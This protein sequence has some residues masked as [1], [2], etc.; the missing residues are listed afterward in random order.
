MKIWGVVLTIAAT[1]AGCT[2]QGVISASSD[3]SEPADSGGPPGEDSGVSPDGGGEP[4]AA[5]MIDSGVHPDAS[6]EDAG[7][8][9]GQTTEDAGKSDAGRLDAGTEKDAGDEIDAGLDAGTAGIDAGEVDAGSGRDAGN[10]TDAGAGKDGGPDAGSATDAGCVNTVVTNVLTYHN[11]LARTGQYLTEA[12]L[13]PSTVNVKQFG[14]LF[15][16]NVDGK[17]DAQPLYMQA[18]TVNGALHNVVFVA[19]EHDSLYAFD[20]DSNA[21]ANANPL[22]KVSLLGT[23]ETTSDTRSC[24]Q[25]TP[26]IGITAT[27]V[28]D[29]TNNTIYVVAMSKN[30]AGTYF[31]RLHAINVLTGAER[32]GSPVTVQAKYPGT[33]DNSSGGF[34]IFDPKQYK[35]RPGLLLLNGQVYTAWSS[36]CDIEPYTGFIVAYDETTLTQTAVINVIPNGSEGSIWMAG[37][38]L[39]VDSN[40]N[41]YFLVANGTF[42]TTLNANGFPNQSDFGN[43]FVRISTANNTLSVVDYFTMSN[44]VSESDADVDLGSG[45]IVL[46][47]DSVGSTA[48][49]HLCVG[50]GK[51]TNIYLVDRDNM[52]HFSPTAN[53]IVQQLSGALPGGIWSIPAYFNGAVYYGSVGSN[54]QRF[55]IANAHM[56]AASKSAVTFP[57]PG[58]F[59]SI[60]AN[61][62]TDPNAIV[63]AYQNSSPAILHAYLA[64]DLTQELYNSN[65][66][67]GGADQFGAGNKY[68]VPTIV[69]GK[70]YVGTTNGVGVFG[71]R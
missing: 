5:T 7:H 34:V 36:H 33:G 54:L 58:T 4:D 11:D 63:W 59:P 10:T 69:N 48:H 2:C 39:A 42:D 29:P 14:K 18:L 26:E 28:I 19:T 24:D 57:Y 9:A 40:S 61:G 6:V 50:A 32:A 30:A 62:P 70:V 23:G 44:T 64:S 25:V 15:V 22:W 16:L 49:P 3:A 13:T 41:I 46:L 31:Q 43:A 27:P 21:G 65:Q 45:G 56:A 51:D 67:A 53:N 38:A 1:A 55:T 60:S 17:V 66:A 8:D 37:G 47:P 68:M 12:C 35:E 52:G 71:L 20:A